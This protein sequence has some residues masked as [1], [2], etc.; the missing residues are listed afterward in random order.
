[1][2]DS[3]ASRKSAAAAAKSRQVARGG[4][5]SSRKLI[6]SMLLFLCCCFAGYFTWGTLQL[7]QHADDALQSVLTPQEP[8]SSAEDEKNEVA[9]AEKGLN[10]LSQASTRAMQTALMAETQNRHPVDLPVALVAAAPIVTTI[11]EIPAAPDPPS[12]VVI[13]VMIT[14]T[15]SAALVSVDGDQDILVRKGTKFSEGKAAI[16]K[17]DAKGV[18]FTWRKKSYRAAL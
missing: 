18:T 15:D 7:L 6:L 14:D 8:D 17:I 4:E 3:P 10:N 9:M 5:G 16:T 1:M 12:L 2:A 13:A 11:G